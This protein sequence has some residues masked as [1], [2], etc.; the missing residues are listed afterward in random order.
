MGK[1][2]TKQVLQLQSVLFNNAEGISDLS[3]E[4]IQKMIDNPQV[5]GRE[6]MKF[7]RNGARLQVIGNHIINTDAAPFIPD[8]WKVEE[9]KKMGQLIWDP[10]KLSLYLSKKQQGGCIEGNKLR[11]ELE[12]KPVMNANVLDYLLA[13]PTL[14]PEEWKGKA[15]YFWGT[16][17]RD[18]DGYLY[19][20]YLCWCDVR[21][22]W[23]C[24]WLDGAWDDNEPA[25][26]RASV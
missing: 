11:K 26:L 21:W 12:G 1:A 4:E 9:H 17:Y 6:F 22:D 3:S 8:G 25:L 13:N 5:S 7:L 20:R 16:I 10:S 2:S 24:P 14:I 18:Y 23:S 15:I 19:V